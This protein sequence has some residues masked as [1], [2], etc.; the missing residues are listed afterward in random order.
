MLRQNT[1]VASGI[2]TVMLLIF[3]KFVVENFNLPTNRV[4]KLGTQIEI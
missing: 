3:K 1:A 4:I 2:L